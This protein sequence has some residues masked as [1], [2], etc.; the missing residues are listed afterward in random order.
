VWFHVHAD[1]GA[2]RN[3]AHNEALRVGKIEL[4]AAV[5]L[6]RGLA[7]GIEPEPPCLRQERAARREGNSRQHMRRQIFTTVLFKLEALPASMFVL[8][9][10]LCARLRYILLQQIVRICKP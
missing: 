1:F 6:N 5:M 8:T 10:K 7:V 2:S 3:R 4:Q 9:Q